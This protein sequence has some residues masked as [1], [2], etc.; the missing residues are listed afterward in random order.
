MRRKDN[1]SQIDLFFSKLNARGIKVIIPASKKQSG[2][3][4]K[5]CGK[6]L[7]D[8]IDDFLSFKE[9]TGI[10]RFSFI[11]EQRRPTAWKKKKQPWV[12]INFSKISDKSNKK[13]ELR[14]VLNNLAGIITSAE[15]AK[16]GEETP[17]KTAPRRIPA[18]DL[19]LE[20]G[21]GIQILVPNTKALNLRADKG[22]G[23][24]YLRKG[25]DPPASLFIYLFTG[26]GEPPE[27]TIAEKRY[28]VKEQTLAELQEGE[29]A[30]DFIDGSLVRKEIIDREFPLIRRNG[31]KIISLAAIKGNTAVT[32]ILSL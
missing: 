25:T 10:N 4:A 20:L 12:V 6:N 14:A 13:G 29:G 22:E 2:E 23:F 21:E 32:E 26:E 30:F 24:L 19:I 18:E 5:R 8:L 27:V 31:A 9:K 17:I 1:M 28:R 3:I 7:D 15:E 16:I 11:L